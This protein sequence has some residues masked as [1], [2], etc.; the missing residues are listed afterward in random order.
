MDVITYF[1]HADVQAWL[2]T[3]KVPSEST[4]RCW[5][6]L[7]QYQYGK[8]LHSM[9]VDG[10]ECIDVVEYRKNI[11]LL[12]WA[13][14]EGRM[15]T[16]WVH[17]TKRAEPVKKGE[18]ASIMVSDFCSLDLGWL[19]SKD[20]TRE[21]RILFK[22]GKNHDGYFDCEDL[23]KQ[24]KLVIELFEDHFPRTAQADDALSAHYMPKFPKVWLG[25]RGKCRMRPGT[26][27]SG[28]PQSFYFPEDHPTMPGWFKG[29]KVIIEERRFVEESNLP[30]ECKSFKCANP[31]G[32]CCCQRIPFNQPNFASQKP[33]LIELLES[34]GHLVFFYPKFHSMWGASKYKYCQLP[35]TENEPAMTKNVKLCLDSIDIIKIQSG[36]N[37]AQA[38]WANKKYHG[39]RV[40][41]ESILRT[42]DIDPVDT[43]A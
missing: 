27:P 37:G 11:F 7:M 42:F 19:R 38:S 23:C 40:L 14:I 8:T 3:K 39:H 20:G 13:S 35:L 15:M 1:H 28:E 16:R 24:T 5:M 10:H 26:L 33:A 18:G 31:K 25:K 22:A 21:A 17:A 12:F 43:V 30:A 34:H 9:Y 32:S 29:M 6:H 2:K 41:P 36:L 4:A